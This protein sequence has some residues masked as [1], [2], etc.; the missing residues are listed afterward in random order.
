MID[1][2]FAAPNIAMP[3]DVTMSP[4]TMTQRGVATCRPMKT[5]KPSV[6]IARPM[7]AKSRTPQRSAKRPAKGAIVAV[8]IAAGTIKRPT[9]AAE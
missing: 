3:N 6:V 7:F 2:E 5:A 9:V 4:A 1:A 8:T